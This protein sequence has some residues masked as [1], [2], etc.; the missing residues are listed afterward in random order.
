MCTLLFK[1]A[2]LIMWAFWL[3]QQFLLLF[4][5]IFLPA[6]VAMLAVGGLSG[7][8]SRYVMGLV[9][10]LAWPLGWA[11]I[12]AGTSAMLESVGET[13]QNSQGWEVGAYLWAVAICMIIPFWIIIG[14]AVAPFVI[15]RMV[16]SGGNAAQGMFSAMGRAAVNTASLATGQGLLSASTPRNITGTGT[17]GGNDAG[18]GGGGR[19]NAGG[20][21][22]HPPGGM[23]GGGSLAGTRQAD[24]SARPGG[25]G[26]TSAGAEPESDAVSAAAAR[27]GASMAAAAEESSGAGSPPPPVLDSAGEDISDRLTNSSRRARAALSSTPVPAA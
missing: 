9:G 8:G 4:N 27:R 26:G 24:P 16:T 2:S 3:A 21:V 25:Q 1:L 14:Y 12:N 15:Q 5:S 13:L 17:G 19:S 7:L 6:F 20:S 11:F 10:L 22:P 23:N 18:D